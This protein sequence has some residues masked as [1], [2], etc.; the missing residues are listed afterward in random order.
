MNRH[1]IAAGC[2]LCFFLPTQANATMRFLDQYPPGTDVSVR[3]LKPYQ[4]GDFIL[5]TTTA[6]AAVFRPSSDYTM[7]GRSSSWFGFAE[8]TLATVSLVPGGTTFRLDSLVV[9]PVSFGTGAPVT[10]SVLGFQESGGP[11]TQTFSAL[12]TATS[13]SLEWTGLTRVEFSADADIGLDDLELTADPP[14][15]SSPRTVLR[16]ENFTQ[17]EIAQGDAVNINPDRPYHESGYVMT[18]LN[19]NA[20]VFDG[21]HFSNMLGIPSDWFGFA[22]GNVVTLGPQ[23]GQS[24]F[25]LESVVT[26]PI[27]LNPFPNQTAITDITITGTLE[28]GRTLSETFSGLTVATKATLGWTGLTNVEFRGTSDSG[29]DDIHVSAVPEPAVTWSLAGG[30]ALIGACAHRRRRGEG[31]RP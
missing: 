3:P 8:G 16:F 26:G 6:L 13:V 20:A 25:S 9:G 15:A 19:D 7:V 30:L 11:L 12:T 5:T 27:L 31:N 22:P 1:F 4:E 18:V 14:V 21:T 10:V 28:D 29:L 17:P 23:A 2:V 24:T